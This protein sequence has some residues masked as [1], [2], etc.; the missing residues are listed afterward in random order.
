M[1]LIQADPAETRGHVQVM[2]PLILAGWMIQSRSSVNN[3]EVTDSFV[4]MMDP[5]DFGAFMIL[6]TF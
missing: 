5:D 4:G 3:I 6:S 1:S 2:G